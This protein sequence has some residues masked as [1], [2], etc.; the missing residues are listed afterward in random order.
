M[1]LSTRLSVAAAIGIIAA[2]TACGSD[3]TGP[4]V[5]HTPGT[6]AQHFDTLYAHAKASSVSDTNFVTRSEL[7]SDLELAAAFGAAP[8]TITVTTSAGTEQWKGFVFEEVHPDT[9]SLVDSAYFVV[10]YR[11]SLVHTMVLAGFLANGTSLGMDLLTND[12]LEINASS[13]SGGVSLTSVG[14][15]CATPIA[16]LVN[17]IITTAQSTT[18]LAAVFNSNLTLAFPAHTG[19]DAALT[20]FSFSATSFAGER[21]FDAS[22]SSDR[23]ALSTMLLQRLRARH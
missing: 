2:T 1:R 3:S 23:V 16:G 5:D 8:T 14:T 15:A 17:P 10:A 21:F 6:L 12:T 22:V 9:G 7:L 11:D 20:A 19:V 18:C 4:P 13:H